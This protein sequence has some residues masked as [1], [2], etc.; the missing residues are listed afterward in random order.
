M[1]LFGKRPGAAAEERIASTGLPA[2]AAGAEN[3]DAIAR[4][5]AAARCRHEPDNVQLALRYQVLTPKTAYLLVYERTKDE[6]PQSMP[7]PQNIAHMLPAGWGGYGSTVDVPM[8]SRRRS[9]SDIPAFYRKSDAEDGSGQG[10]TPLGVHEWL[11]ATPLSQW[12]SSYTE[13]MQRDM[14]AVVGWLQSNMSHHGG[15]EYGEKTVVRTFLHVMAGSKTALKLKGCGS[16][17]WECVWDGLRGVLAAWGTDATLAAAMER[18]LRDMDEMKW[19]PE[20]LAFVEVSEEI[21]D[22]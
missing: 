8:F 9:S 2:S 6:K 13:L 19:S 10:L 21:S 12:P 17:F 4:M 7:Q 18:A 16:S 5:A 3:A 11:R 22:G 15:K 14:G 20:I 1:Q